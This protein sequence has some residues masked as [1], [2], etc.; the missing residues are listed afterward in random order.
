MYRSNTGRLLA[1][2]VVLTLGVAACSSRDDNKTATTGSTK[3]G[4]NTQDIDTS[5]CSVDPT[6][7]LTGN[8]ITLASS[9]PQSGQTAAFAE[10]SHGWQAYFNML[11]K[12]KGG[13]T[14]AGKKFM[15]KVKNADDEYQSAKTLANID[16]A[17]GNG[18]QKNAFATFQVVGTANNVTIRPSL[19]DM[20]VPNLF[21]ATGSPA[22]GDPAFP[23]TIGATNAPYTIEPTAFAEYLKRV[24]PD[25]TVAELVQDDDFGQAYVD[26][27]KKAIEGS[28]IKVVGVEKYQTAADNVAPQITTLAATDA[29]A[30]IVGATLLKC[31]DAFTRADAA[32]WKPLSYVSGT[33][34]GKTLMGIAGSAGDKAFTTAVLK[35]P[36]NPKWD[37]DAAMKEYKA[38]VAK[39]W[40]A[41]NKPDLQNGIILYG[42]T[43]A[44]LLEKVMAAA[45]APTRL[46]VMESARHMNN[47]SAPLL[48][49]GI[50]VT[51][52]GD[53][54]PYMTE[55]V[56]VG[57]YNA[58]KG[59]FEDVGKIESFEGKTKDITPEN[60]ITG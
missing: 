42:W 44:A 8:T 37:T 56:Q 1:V 28:K 14:L 23:W 33:C 11:N 4:D 7:P 46:A 39:Y 53:E 13:I 20:C 17:V 40:T 10:I 60:L 3:A 15:I 21:A 27:F 32:G 16:K 43:Q 47:V 57:Q 49:P 6:Q 45:K 5:N 54:D 34:S 59:Y 2:L 51:T 19:N 30:F 24:K 58:A 9:S 48:R 26:G 55:S 36:L 29:D 31:P 25:A 41:S 38:N 12:T 22:W 35:D 50:T 18:D 52:N